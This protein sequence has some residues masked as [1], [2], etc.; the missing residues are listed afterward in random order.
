MISHSWSWQ[1]GEKKALE[2]VMKVIQ[3]NVPKIVEKLT[4]QFSNRLTEGFQHLAECRIRSAEQSDTQQATM[5]RLLQLEVA[6]EGRK[7]EEQ[8]SRL[9]HASRDQRWL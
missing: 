7:V 3:T 2:E 9:L 6:G 4:E 8:L 5:I 1:E